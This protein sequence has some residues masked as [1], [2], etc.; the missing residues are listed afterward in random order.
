[1]YKKI[2]KKVKIALLDQ[3]TA[4]KS[5]LNALSV[6]QRETAATELKEEIKFRIEDLKKKGVREDN[7]CRKALRL[8][9]SEYEARLNFRTDGDMKKYLH[10]LTKELER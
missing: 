10:K 4:L 2:N 5:L 7:Q 1:M 8:V 9:S 6:V 3:I